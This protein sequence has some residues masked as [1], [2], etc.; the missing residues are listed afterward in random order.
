M[1]DERAAARQI[2]LAMITDADG[3]LAF[4]NGD[5]LALGW[6]ALERPLRPSLARG[7]DPRRAPAPRGSRSFERAVTGKDGAG[8][9][10][11]PLRTSDGRVRIVAWSATP[12]LGED[13]A[14]HLASP[15]WGWT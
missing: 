7:P 3:R 6:V 11:A 9:V 1:G 15:R 2:V 4:A 12:S 10:E 5:L 13:W 8:C 14:A